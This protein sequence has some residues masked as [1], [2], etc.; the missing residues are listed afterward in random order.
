[1]DRVT[2][3]P[4]ETSAVPSTPA[5]TEEQSSDPLS[6]ASALLDTLPRTES[7]A[8][9]SALTEVLEALLSM[10]YAPLDLPSPMESVVHLPAQVFFSELVEPTTLCPLD[11]APQEWP[12]PAELETETS[13]DM[14]ATLLLHS[15][16]QLLTPLMP[17]AKSVL[18]LEECAQL[19]TLPFMDW[20]VIQ[21]EPEFVSISNAFPESAPHPYSL[22]LA[23][24]VLA[25]P[26][27]PVTFTLMYAAHPRPPSV[28]FVPECLR[29]LPRT[30]D[31]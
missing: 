20:L 12:D 27:T 7:A 1:M 30:A 21:L 6:T 11:L 19:D 10:E 16:A 4:L 2:L 5:P 3:A 25:P 18:L 13:L 29:L 15:A 17:H 14:L 9:P 26:A 8:Q 31:H 28:G 22:A 24:M 23:P